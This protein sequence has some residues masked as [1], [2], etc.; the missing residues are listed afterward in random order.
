MVVWM[1]VR[2]VEKMVEWMVG[3]KDD[4]LDENWVL[5][6]VDLKAQKMAE[7]MVLN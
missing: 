3:K 2:L 6:W 5:K 1:V 4:M 7:W